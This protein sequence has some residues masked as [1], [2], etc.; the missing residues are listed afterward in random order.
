MLF[1]AWR[2]TVCFSFSKKLLSLVLVLIPNYQV[3]HPAGPGCRCCSV[4]PRIFMSLCHLSIKGTVCLYNRPNYV[5]SCEH[6]EDVA[7]VKKSV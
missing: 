6:L 4:Q 7:E 5:V 2:N 3:I 1:K